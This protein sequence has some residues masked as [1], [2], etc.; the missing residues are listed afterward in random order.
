ME[1]TSHVRVRGGPARYVAAA[2]A[3]VA[4]LIHFGVAPEHFE[5]GRCPDRAV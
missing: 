5:E 3:L 2:L 4:G 1:N